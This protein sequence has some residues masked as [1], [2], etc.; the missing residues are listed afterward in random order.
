MLPADPIT[1][2]RDPF[3]NEPASGSVIGWDVGGAHLK[4]VRVENGE[5]RAARQE[6]L[7]LWLGLKHLEK[8]MTAIR[9]DLGEVGRHRVTMTG[10]LVDAFAS[11][12]EGV[13]AIAGTA[14]RLLGDDVLIWGG[15]AG[16][17]TAPEAG[18]RAEDVASANWHATATFVAGR[19]RD[20]ILLDIGS[21]TTDV[22]PIKEG[23]VAAT[24]YSDATRFSSG[25]LVY[26]GA[27]RT[28][29]M[30]VAQR[31]PFRGG[32]SGVAAEYFATMAD[33]NRLLGRLDEADDR[34]PPADGR[35]KSLDESRIRL[36]RMVGADVGDATPDDWTGLAAWFAESQIR[37]VDDAL[38]L[39][40]SR[41]T[42]AADAPIVACGIGREPAAELARRQG[43][44]IEDLAALMP[45]AD[46]DLARR[47]AAY[48][49]AASV[50]LL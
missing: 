30:A 39:V 2:A 33:V 38:R 29:L 32:W 4:A 44:T 47:A 14:A 13:A 1:Q 43:R 24:G 25:E 34:Y 11:R 46:A 50:A 3:P 10:E 41:S 12:A 22:I 35:G 23:R 20:A 40:A 16:W 6:A 27:V 19:R 49:P 21:T 15:R 26:T 37:L 9:A 28:P 36:A 45:A 17:L 42:L 31:A 7:P 18:R 5:V 48:A 8:A